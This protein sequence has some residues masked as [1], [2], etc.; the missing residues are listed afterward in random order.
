M[1]F[2]KKSPFQPI[3]LVLA[4][5][6]AFA[7][8]AHAAQSDKERI[9]ELEK[10]LERS[11]ALIEQLNARVGHLEAPKG[12]NSASPAIAAAVD[13]E[14]KS[15]MAEAQNFS[16]KKDEVQLARIDQLEK[17]LMQLSDGTAK[18][19]D[20]GT[21]LHGFTD[22]SY[23]HS[24]KDIDNRKSGFALGNMDLYLTPEFG[25][26]RVKTLLELVFEFNEKGDSVG[27]DL[28]RL[29]IGYTFNDELT[30]WA[31]RVHTP[32]GFWNTGFHHGAQLQ[33]SIN[34]PRMVDFEDKGG[35][36]P[37]HSVGVMASGS[38]RVPGGRV[39]YDFLLANGSRI[40]GEPGDKVLDYNGGKDDNNNKAFGGNIRY[41]LSGALDGLTLGAHGLTEEIDEAG[42]S[43]K[44]TLNMLGGFAVVDT[45]QLEIIVEYY[46]FNNKDISGNTGTHHSWSGFA[47]AG[48][49]LNEQWTPFV[50]LEKANLDQTDNYFLAQHSGR[51]YDRQSL[52]VRYNLSDSSALKLEL[53][54]TTEQQPGGEFKFNEARVQFAVRF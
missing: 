23:V 46:K 17:N 3:K 27:T 18:K 28:E 34:K 33:P 10:K 26:G 7:L 54:K 25:G 4:I 49:R 30:L 43:N 53:G 37:S 52:G 19:R 29:Q 13:A 35:I 44:T 14:V 50:R 42:T 2:R 47:H 12:A 1:N 16:A 36:L 21:P 39:E 8:P 45:D 51:S 15:K 31:G 22:V 20:M 24:S 48:Y 11:M 38:T 40:A 32:Y 5:S 41:R 6:L 9:A